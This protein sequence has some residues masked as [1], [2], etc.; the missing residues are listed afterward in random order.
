MFR[1][2]LALPLIGHGLAHVSGFIATWTNNDAGFA[3]RPWIFSNGVT[4]GSPLGKV[5]GLLWLA[6]AAAL[7][8]SGA[9]LILQET[10]WVTLAVLG[11]ILSLLVIVPWWNSVP[12][13]AKIGAAFDVILLVVLLTPLKDWLLP[14][15]G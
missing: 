2:F 13:G 14:L 8:G 10:W 12:P 15:L 1:F 5:F 6:A 11:S 7:A 9:G 4:L 3:P